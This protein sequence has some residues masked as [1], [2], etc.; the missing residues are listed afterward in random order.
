MNQLLDRTHQPEFHAI[1]LPDIPVFDNSELPDGAMLHVMRGGTQ[2]ITKIDIIIE[3]GTLLS[4]K[5]LVARATSTLLSEGTRTRTSAQI[6]EDLDYYGAY[7]WQR[8][9]LKRTTLSL[10]CLTKHV[11]QIVPIIEEI[12]KEP[13]FPDNELQLYIER[14]RQ[15]F[16]IE[17]CRTTYRARTALRQLLYAPTCRYGRVAK[18]SDFGQLRQGDLVDFHQD[19]YSPHNA[20]IFISGQPDDAA[21]DIIAHAFGENWE[22][23]E[24]AVYPL[25][26]FGERGQHE[27][28]D[29]A[30]AKQ[31]SIC[32]ARHTPPTGHADNQKLFAANTILGGYFGSRLMQ[33]IREEKGLTYGIGSYLVVA[34]YGGTLTIKTDVRPDKYE[35]VI[36]EIFAE[37]QRMSTELVGEEELTMVRN[38]MKGEMLRQFDSTLSSADTLIPLCVIGRGR[39]HFEELDRTISEITPEEIRSISERYLRPEDFCTVVARPE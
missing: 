12:V 29:V 1:A 26:H 25:P 20:H 2:P 23:K 4:E 32:I 35:L 6:A 18:L 24:K 9:G 38:Y 10:A 22:P 34:E 7:L 30:N 16:E 17:Q 37:M 27:V 11:E 13:S 39:E 33:N 15:E 14:C 19:T 5:P 28:I 3:S 8:T 31:A 36:D 21:V